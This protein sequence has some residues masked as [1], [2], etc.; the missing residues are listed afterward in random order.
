MTSSAPDASGLGE[1]AFGERD[2]DTFASGVLWTGT[3]E[4]R[5]LARLLGGGVARQVGAS[6]AA[7]CIKARA[8]VVVAPA[9]TS[10]DLVSMAVPYRF[11]AS[12]T[13]L[14]VA[15]VG[16]GPHSLLAAHLAHRLS[17]Q[18]EV[19][20]LAVCGYGPPSIRTEAEGVLAELSDRL[21]DLAVQAVQVPRPAAI[22]EDLPEDTLVVVGA[23][24]GTWLERRFFGPG[25]RIRANAPGGVIVVKQAAPRVFQIMGP[26]V[27]FEPNM[28]ASDAAVLSGDRHVIV[29]QGERLVGIASRRALQ[30][31]PVGVELGEVADHPVF[32]LATQ[33]TDHAA[34]LVS[35]YGEGPIPVVDSSGRLVGSVPT[36]ALAK[37]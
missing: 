6:L 8:T 23:P 29:A 36:S 20:A 5:D 7:S 19:P 14:V 1:V 26:A 25:A 13:R 17:R 9:I 24:G 3:A 32:L 4:T 22:V 30:E 11:T 35:R 16:G 10:F 15:A 37:R 33:P 18:L 12:N 28:S 34:E 31:A 21:P 2:S 27:A